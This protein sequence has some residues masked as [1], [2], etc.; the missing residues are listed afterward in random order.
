MARPRGRPALDDLDLMEQEGRYLFARADLGRKLDRAPTVA[1][2]ADYMEVSTRTV[3]AIRSR[4]R[5][6]Q[7]DTAAAL[8][9]DGT[10]DVDF[11]DGLTGWTRDRD[12]ALGAFVL[13]EIT[14]AEA[15]ELLGVVDERTLRRWRSNL[16]QPQ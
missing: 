16:R 6:W 7:R 8:G 3:V 2:I 1:E 15:A 13:G 14:A 4:F 5:R 9:W 12:Y 10:N 11:L